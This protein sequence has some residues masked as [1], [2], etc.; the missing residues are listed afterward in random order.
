MLMVKAHPVF[1]VGPLNFLSQFQK[2][3]PGYHARVAHNAFVALAAESGIPSAFL[4]VSFIAAAITDMW[5]TRR[6]LLQFPHLSELAA[7]CLILQL[8]LTVYVIPNFF[9]NRQNLDLM[10]HLVGLSVALSALAK[11][12]MSETQMDESA[13]GEVLLIEE[14]VMA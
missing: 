6:Q 14:P 12:K 5:W 3:F 1:G 2:Y 11:H 10:Y 7:Q 13:P 9:I 8:A 4:F